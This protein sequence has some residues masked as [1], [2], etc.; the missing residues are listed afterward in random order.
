MQ[1]PSQAPKA[2]HQAPELPHFW[3]NR[4]STIVNANSGAGVF[5]LPML[6]LYCASKFALEGFSE[7]LS[8]ELASQAIAVKVVEPG[9]VLSTNCGR[10]SAEEAAGNPSRP[11]GNPLEGGALR[12]SVSSTAQPASACRTNGTSLRRN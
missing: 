9:G 2:S 12:A 1:P 5:T 11:R 7:S 4:G 10:R 8:Y 6:L 3:A